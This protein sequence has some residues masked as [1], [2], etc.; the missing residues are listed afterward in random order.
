[1]HFFTDRLEISL[2]LQRIILGVAMSK[3][4]IIAREAEMAELKR[5]YESDR[6]EFVIV[7]G[8][9]RVGKTF[10][11]DT[12][13]EKKYDFTYVG[14]HKLTKAKQLRGFAKALKKAS[15][16]KLQPKLASWDDAFDAL[17]EYIESLPQEKRKVIFIDEMPWIDTPQSEFVEALETFWNGWGARRTDIMLIASGSA[18]SWMMDKLVDNPGGLHAR[19]TN[20]IYI[21]PFTLKETEEYLRWRGIRWSHYQI[22][23][24]YMVMGGIPFYLSLLDPKQTLIGN[25]DR[26]FFR[27]NAELRTEF[28]ELYNAVFHKADKYLEVVGLLN[29]NHSGMTF[30]EIQK[31]TTLDGDR[32]TTALKNLERCDFIVSFQQFGNKSRG[33]LYRLVDFYTLFYYRFV[34]AIDSKDEQ[35]WT[36]NYNSHSVESWQGY[37]FE[38]ICFTHLAQIRQRLGISGISTSASSW[39]YTPAK[40]EEAKKA[41]IDLVI[42]RGDRIINLCE[43]KFCIGPYTI[44]KPYADELRQRNQLFKEKEKTNYGLNCTFVTT[45]GVADGVNK[46][47]VDSEVTAEDLFC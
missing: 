45:F 26:L 1:M 42:E 31:A 15:G 17:E 19:I 29:G 20:N 44:K 10:L 37:A 13:F 22:L 27:K 18:S 16:M 11:V 3:A 34:E 25:I 46:D 38:L 28:D 47:I 33:K 21:R 30:T 6:S 9:R 24:L 2:F 32:L 41:Q 12:F 5:C 8:R 35:W 4:K 43:M 36:H 40:N 23:Q 14:G 39:R 7:Y